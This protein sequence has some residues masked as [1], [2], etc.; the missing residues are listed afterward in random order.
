[1]ASSDNVILS[2]SAFDLETGTDCQYDYLEVRSATRCFGVGEGVGGVFCI[3]VCLFVVFGGY[4][5]V[6]L[7]VLVYCL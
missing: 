6:C 3:C 5:C 1:M 7:R 4:V 2:F